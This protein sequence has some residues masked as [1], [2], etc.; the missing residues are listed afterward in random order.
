MRTEISFPGIAGSSSSKQINEFLEVHD[1]NRNKA[2]DNS[3]ITLVLMS[4]CTA[5]SH[6]VFATLPGM[7]GSWSLQKIS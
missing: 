1:I 7:A 4:E 5:R 2:K 6:P 3:Q